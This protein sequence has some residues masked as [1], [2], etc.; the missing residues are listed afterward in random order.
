M[1]EVQGD[2][3][4]QEKK[5]TR[6]FELTDKRYKIDGGKLARARE[7]TGLNQSEFAYSCGWTSG[8][9]WQLENGR[10]DTVSE[11]TKN[12]IEDVFQGRE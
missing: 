3:N 5:G 2:D 11:A 10:V 4:F 8:Y 9:Q 6:M 12:V 1:Q 7:K